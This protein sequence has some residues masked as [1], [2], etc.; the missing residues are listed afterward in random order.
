MNTI[1]RLGVISNNKCFSVLVYYCSILLQSIYLSIVQH[2][3]WRKQMG[4]DALL[5]EWQP[6]D[7]LTKYS[8]GGLFGH[9]KEG[10]PIWIEPIGLA[11]VQG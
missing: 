4:V 10:C 7:V 6:P 1:G 3:E 8:P 11:D 9:D 2:L 5:N